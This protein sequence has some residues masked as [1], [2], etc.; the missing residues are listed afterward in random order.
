MG[1][2][3]GRRRWSEVEV[4]AMLREWESSGQTLT[5]FARR[6]GYVPERLRR[7]KKKLEGKPASGA[8]FVPVE[9]PGSTAALRSGASPAERRVEIAVPGGLRVVLVDP[10]DPALVACLVVELR[11]AGC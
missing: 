5:A 8:R 1:R 9:I 2:A 11:G 3:K 6:R 7:W 4:R 10:I